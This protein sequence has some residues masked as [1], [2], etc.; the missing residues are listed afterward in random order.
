MKKYV[1]L[2]AVCA[3]AINLS[4]TDLGTIQVESSTID[5]KFDTKKQRYLQLH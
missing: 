2:S 1:H 4:A 3:L 5:D